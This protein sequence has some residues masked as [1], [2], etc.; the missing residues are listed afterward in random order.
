MDA[1]DLIAPA[2][3][4]TIAAT[5][6]TAGSAAYNPELNKPSY[7]GGTCI[8][9]DMTGESMT[10]SV[11]GDNVSKVIVKG[12]TENKVYTQAPFTNLTA[13]INPNTGKPYAISHV[14]VCSDGTTA[15]AATPNTPA[16][17]QGGGQVNGQST[18]QP[19]PA[20][21]ATA[22]PV[23]GGSGAAVPQPAVAGA[24]DTAAPT[25]IASTGP[26][27]VVAASA[28]IGGF[29]YALT[30]WFRRKK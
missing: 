1:R 26:E 17:V 25:E 18:T 16:S 29:V 28:G 12:G 11:D 3:A 6:V 14:I 27:S 22:T 21:P 4:I 10:Y 2:A 8:K 19:K 7:W 9:T 20:T 23:A 13:P 24:V 15:P 30:H 5:N